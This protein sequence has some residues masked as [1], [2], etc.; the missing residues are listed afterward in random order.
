MSRYSL[1]PI[2]PNHEIAVGF[3]RAGGS[4]G[5]TFFG[6][7]FDIE[8]QDKIE[9]GEYANDEELDELEESANIL[10]VGDDYSQPITNIDEIEQIIAPY[11]TITPDIKQQLLHDQ[12]VES[13]L[14]PSAFKEYVPLT[15]KFR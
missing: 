13:Q 11:A 8:I 9:S 10:V 14:A 4:S 6:Q 12:Q 3:D 15:N 5:A 7:V 1:A 2:N